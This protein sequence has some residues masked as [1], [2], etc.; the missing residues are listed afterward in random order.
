MHIVDSII[1]PSVIVISVLF[2]YLELFNMTL[3]HKDTESLRQTAEG[4]D[5]YVN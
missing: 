4:A 1:L 3:F 5:A 2:C